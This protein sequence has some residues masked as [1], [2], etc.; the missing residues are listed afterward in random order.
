MIY[1]KKNFLSIWT[2]LLF[3]VS[4]SLISCSD[5]GGTGSGKDGDDVGKLDSDIQLYGVGAQVQVLEMHPTGL[6]VSNLAIA[7]V[8]LKVFT[9]DTIQ[10]SFLSTGKELP[11][12]TAIMKMYL[13]NKDNS[14]YQMMLDAQASSSSSL[15]DSALSSS[16]SL[17]NIEESS[18]S[19]AQVEIEEIWEME[20]SIETKCKAEFLFQVVIT[21]VNGTIASSDYI[22][23]ESS[24]FSECVL[25]NLITIQ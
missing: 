9:L 12:D 22:S 21:D 6:I 13:G 7:E 23:F 3:I 25:E 16:S 8:E 14:L 11:A 1:T 18:S 15:V 17:D 2:I 5:D 20:S 19:F 4:F 10:L 24:A